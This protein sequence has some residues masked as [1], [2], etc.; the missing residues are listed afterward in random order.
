MSN[1]RNLARP[2]YNEILQ[3]IDE[4]GKLSG[5]VIQ[6]IYT[7]SESVKEINEQIQNNVDLTLEEKMKLVDYHN[8]IWKH[9]NLKKMF[10]ETTIE[11]YRK[12]FSKSD[13]SD[14]SKYKVS[15]VIPVYNK[16]K[17]IRRSIES[18]INQTHK[19]LKLFALMTAQLITLLLS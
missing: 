5:S 1:G 18:C 16:E 11:D 19:I 9:T 6:N 8:N 10:I 4:V 7:F 15:I 2:S 12:E 3:K 14:L 17:W 13:V